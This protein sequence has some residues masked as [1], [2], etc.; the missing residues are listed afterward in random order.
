MKAVLEALL[1]GE[2]PPVNY[3]L[4][5]SDVQAV[6]ACYD[7]ESRVDESNWSRGTSYETLAEMVAGE[8]EGFLADISRYYGDD[9]YLDE[10][11]VDYDDSMDGDHESALASCGWGTDEDYGS[12]GGEDF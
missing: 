1:A 8:P 12:F 10:E 11:D 5:E 2:D 3:G 6:A 7:W 4:T 9:H